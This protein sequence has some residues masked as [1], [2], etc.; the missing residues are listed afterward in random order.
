MVSALAASVGVIIALVV[1]MRDLA[2]TRL[3]NSA[4]MVLQ[5]VDRFDSAEM[6]NYRGQFAKTLLEARNSID[7]RWD[8][9]VLEFFEEVGY[10]THRR[11]LDEGMVWNSFSW[12]FEPYYS[13]VR[14]SPDLIADARSKT[15]FPSLFREIE[16]LY[17]RMNKVSEREERPANYIS[18]SSDDVNNFLMEEAKLAKPAEPAAAP[19]RGG[20]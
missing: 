2:N 3:S 12:W 13:S 4:K 8:M 1:H 7:V 10:M 18:P 11:V 9:P 14:K 17:G 5:L 20:L 6:R 15:T 19:D 16:W